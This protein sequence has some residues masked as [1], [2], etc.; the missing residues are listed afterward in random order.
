MAIQNRRKHLVENKVVVCSSYEELKQIVPNVGGDG[1]DGDLFVDGEIV[2]FLG[3][4]PMDYEILDKN[5][6]TLCERP[7]CA[8]VFKN[9]IEE[10]TIG[11]RSFN[12]D[13]LVEDIDH[14]HPLVRPADV[15]K[16]SRELVKDA[17]Y[18]VI[19]QPYAGKYSTG[20]KVYLKKV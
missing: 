16:T 9:D 17:Q 14:R 12:R 15:V 2:T 6:V 20:W 3:F 7:Y 13:P 19:V 1:S 11:A 5:G 18:K 8:L 10:K 4:C